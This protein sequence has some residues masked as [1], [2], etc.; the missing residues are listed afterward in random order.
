MIFSPKELFAVYILISIARVI[1]ALPLE[2]DQEHDV[3][4]LGNADSNPPRNSPRISERVSVTNHQEDRRDT[5]LRK[6]AR[7]REVRT[8]VICYSEEQVRQ[9]YRDLIAA[10][11]TPTSRHRDWDA[12]DAQ[13]GTEYTDGLIRQ[14]E[15]QCRECRCDYSNRGARPEGFRLIVAG[16]TN[17]HAVPT[18]N[19]CMNILGCFCHKELVIEDD[20]PQLGAERSDWRLNQGFD[21]IPV[22]NEF[23]NLQTYGGNSK[24]LVQRPNYW[25]EIDG[26]FRRLAPGTKEPYYLEGPGGSG[27]WFES[28]LR[29][30]LGGFGSPRRAKG[31]NKRSDIGE[32]G[33]SR[34]FIE[35]AGS[36]SGVHRENQG[37]DV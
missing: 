5:D 21:N 34:S 23:A 7:T 13:Y 19:I 28:I 8:G 15:A 31:L 30:G 33:V 11:H 16:G 17:C 36:T 26:S 22:A 1:G 2:T 3:Y 12:L 27:T 29:D 24:G 9:A 20:E 6:R 37:G 14:L 32:G 4:S 35:I 10:G 25:E 18:V